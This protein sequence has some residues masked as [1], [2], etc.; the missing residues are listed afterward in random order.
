MGEEGK[1]SGSAAGTAALHRAGRHIEDAGCLGDGVALH[2]HQ[3]EGGALVGRESAQCAYELAVE[4][5]ALGRSGGGLVWFEELLQVLGVVDGGRLPG[6][7]LAGAVQAGVH[8]DAVQPGRDGRLAAEGV[9]GAVGRDERVLDRVSG[10]LAVSQRSQGH[11][12]QA[13]AMAPHKLTEGL[14]IAPDMAGKEVLIVCFAIS[15]FIGHR[16]PSPPS[17]IV[18]R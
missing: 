6:R 8:R 11:R 12:P 2:V 7:R 1:Q 13:V 9:G 4:I 15:G 5:I 14:G 3:D 10:L 18:S 16:T 17:T